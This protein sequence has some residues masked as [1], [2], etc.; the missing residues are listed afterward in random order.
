MRWKKYLLVFTIFIIWIAFF[1]QNSLI[2]RYHLKKEL[3][4]LNTQK[5]YLLDEIGKLDRQKQMLN[6]GLDSLEKFAR[7][8]YFM[9][10]PSEDV[11]VFE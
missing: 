6:G 10:K 8:V 3:S 1:D 11:Y 2:Y 7:E 4:K 5:S 9:K